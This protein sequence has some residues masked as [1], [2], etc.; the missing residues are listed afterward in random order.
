MEKIGLHQSLIYIYHFTP[1]IQIFFYVPLFNSLAKNNY[2]GGAFASCCPHLT[3]LHQ[4][5]N[6]LSLYDIVGC[7]AN[8]A[9]HSA[10]DILYK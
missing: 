3:N 1:P 7:P 5:I 10:C 9:S 4:W 2:I 8:F 6:I